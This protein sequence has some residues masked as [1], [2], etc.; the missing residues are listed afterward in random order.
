MELKNFSRKKIE[1][2]KTVFI[3][4]C[5][6]TFLTVYS[7]VLPAITIDYDTAEEDSGI[8][9][10]ENIETN[11]TDQNISD[12]RNIEND[13]D[14]IEDTEHVEPENINNIIYDSEPLYPAAV[15]SECFDD[16]LVYVEAPEGAFPENTKLVIREANDIS[17]E[18]NISDVVERKNISSY[19][20]VDIAFVYDGIEIEPLQ[21]IKVSITSSFISE[22]SED[23]LLV[24]ID[25]DGNAKEIS[26]QT[27]DQKDIDLISN[28]DDIQDLINSN[29]AIEEISKENT[30][31]F[32]SD[33]FSVYVLV[34]TVDFHY[35]IDEKSF[36]YSMDG[37]NAIALS[38]LLDVLNVLEDSEDDRDIHDFIND[39][40][41]LSFSDE[42]LVKILPVESD[43]TYQELINQYDLDVEYSSSLSDEDI[44]S[45]KNKQFNEGDYVLISLRPFDSEELLAISLNNGEQLEI[46]VRDAQISKTILTS[47]GERFRISI[48]YDDEAMIPEGSVLN[49]NEITEGSDEYENYITLTEKYWDAANRSD[50]INVVHY[51]DIEIIDPEGF[52]IEPK[53][54]VEVTIEH[55]NGF[56]DEKDEDV[57]VIHFMEEEIELIEEVKVDDD[58]SKV[59]Y[60]QNSFSVIGTVSTTKSNGWPTSNGQHILIF[61]DG[62]NYY[63]LDHEGNL[64][65]VRYF[66]G[67]VSFTGEGTTTVN[68]IR[69]YI[70]HVLSNTNNARGRIS[71]EYYS[72]SGA[73]EDQMFICPSS[74]AVDGWKI[75]AARQIQINKDSKKIYY[76]FMGESKTL[77]V[78]DGV[79]HTVPLDDPTGSPVLF[80]PLSSFRANENETDLFTQ[81]EVE[82]IVEMWKD[83][84]TDYFTYDKT[85]EVHDY[86][87][88]V[89]RLDMVASSANYQVS[90]SVVLEFVVDASRSMFFPTSL[91]E[92]GTFTGTDKTGVVNWMIANGEI[93]QTYFVI[94]DKDGTA[95]QY[96]IYYDTEWGDWAQC[97]ASYYNPPD[98][99]RRRDR[100]S[101]LNSNNLNDGKIYVTEIT[102]RS[103]SVSDNFGE[104]NTY[105]SRIE[106]LKQCVRVAAQ[107]IYA[108]DDGAQIGLITF[109][110]EIID[111]GT[112]GK[113]QQSELLQ[114]LDGIS[115]K[116]GTNTLA[117]M[118][119]ALDKYDRNNTAYWNEHYKNRKH[120]VVLVTDGAPNAKVNG[121]QQNYTWDR[122]IKPVAEALK[123]KVDDFGNKTELYTMGLS[124][125]NVGRNKEGMFS[126]A[127]GSSYCYDAEDAMQIID[128]V[129][130]MVDG[131]LCQASIIADVKDVIDPLFYPIDLLSGRP[132]NVND[133]IDLSGNKTEVE[134]KK[135]GQLKKDAYGNWYV[136]WK[137]QNIDWPTLDESGSIKEPGWHGT[138]YVKAKEDFLGGNGLNTNLNG[139]Q[140]KAKHYRIVGETETKPVPSG[141]RVF[142]FSTP[143]VNV[144]ELDITNNSTSW[145]VYLGTQVDPLKEVKA[146][147]EKISIKEVVSKSDSN[148]VIAEGGSYT[149]EFKEDDSDGRPE[150][151][152]REEFL[153]KDIVNLNEDQ[154]QLLLN[155]TTVTIPY[156]KYGHAS[157]GTIQI[158]L[159]Q[160]VR[161]GEEDLSLSPH[162]AAVTGNSV[163]KY[164][165]TVKY[166]MSNPSIGDWHTGS[167]GT[168]SSGNKANNLNKNNIHTI[169]VYAKGLQ[170]TKV[171]LNDAVL[172]GA[173]FALFRTA[174][175]DETSD[176]TINNKSFH[177]VTELDTSTSGVASIDAIERLLPNEEYYLVETQAPAGYLMIE[178]IKVSLTIEDVYTPKPGSDTQ[179]TKPE[180]GIYDWVQNSV[181]KLVVDSGVK[182][183]DADNTDLTHTAIQANAV[184]DKAYY[185]IINNPGVELPHTGG[186]GTGVFKYCGLMLMAG[187]ILYI[188]S[189]RRSR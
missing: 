79:L 161:E 103:S 141:Q 173:K 115:L 82:L 158:L 64:K 95:K 135:A 131:I 30:L 29:D 17:L 60:V 67:T 13:I 109:N 21:A 39:I 90:P 5:I 167:Y 149:Y 3:L 172:K 139:S 48:I 87:N 125:E 150:I 10:N 57:S 176:I 97:D 100:L 182:R 76:T 72:G 19:K 123:Y 155:G 188:L 66:N 54:P 85:A 133:W 45:L 153:L 121:V 94:E 104:R 134:S 180:S 166:N 140:I 185:R 58:G 70:W 114:K 113:N 165:L 183:T 175:A 49:V 162:K 73:V 112:F 98:G 171:D 108:V 36:D 148:H 46:R 89:Y 28:N 189:K 130:N 107:V 117:A 56:L 163:E 38:E 71:D 83:Q 99:Q 40:E 146:L 181:L 151:N 80:A 184:G 137:D 51:F 126:V 147:W 118:Q 129:A 169:N 69:N 12:N 154:W 34:Y 7:L 132:L 1:R 53:T 15:F 2:R 105:V 120:V 91:T 14:L 186:I 47:E 24:H 116:G 61:Q 156:A 77:S 42:S 20:A 86:E 96:A 8:F 22:K 106:Y 27:L 25:N 138:V 43:C 18:D 122:D 179:E 145:T 159:T 65:K 4:S 127:T 178:P 37:G 62:D 136:E 11:N 101:N 52:T 160:N 35:E 164:T 55:E 111:Q 144:D 41:S 174:R 187:S 59:D 33:S 177:R 31:S 92:V 157:V 68:Y 124:L 128:A 32:E 152:G 81:E 74:D 44:E 6:V 88:R 142:D 119:M 78:K 9:L 63:A 16:F 102:G 143:Y 75:N 170:I 168:G 110:N 84:L 26:T 50:L 23:P 93:G